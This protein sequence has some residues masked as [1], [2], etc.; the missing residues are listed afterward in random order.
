MVPQHSPNYI[1]FGSGRFW[2]Q[3]L[4]Q[5]W[6]KPS[7]S[8]IQDKYSIIIDWSGDSYLGLTINWNHENGHVDISMPDYVPKALAKFKHPKPHIPQHASHAWR[9]P[10]YRNQLNTLPL[11]I[12]L[13]WMNKQQT[14]TRNILNFSILCT[15]CQSNYTAPAQWNFQSAGQ[16]NRKN[17]ENMQT[18]NGLFIHAS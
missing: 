11:I 12:P 1:H 14:R 18:T 15:G 16:A 9:M 13:F 6:R 4:Q 3:T 17:N 2:H 7:F 5:G 10:I 8:V